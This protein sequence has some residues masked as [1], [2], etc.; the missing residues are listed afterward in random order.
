M[1][2]ED[3]RI[4]GEKPVTATLKQIDNLENE[5]WLAFPEGYRDFMVRFG[6]G[7]IGDFLRIYPPWRIQATYR[8]WRTRIDQYWFWEKG[9]KVLPKERA[10]ECFPIG[11]TLNG[12]ELV[13]HPSRPNRFFVLP[14]EAEKVFEIPGTLADAIEWICSSGR[15]TRAIRSRD[16]TAFDSRLIE[17][18]L[19]DTVIQ[20]PVGESIEDILQLFEKWVIRHKPQ[21]LA[22]ENLKNVGLKG[23]KPILVEES[24]VL[25]EKSNFPRKPGYRSEWQVVDMKTEDLIGI[26]I[27]RFSEG[28]SSLEYSPIETV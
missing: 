7:T 20:D 26:F 9:R 21:G 19:D 16:F 3:I 28:M 25:S 6:E 18:Y 24:L 11:D 10:I 1:S 14:G 23:Y 12:D 2:F 15:L 17:E 4:V 8:E 13:I 27:F 5:F 22:K